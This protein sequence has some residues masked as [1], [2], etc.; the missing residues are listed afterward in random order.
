VRILNTTHR[1][2]KLTRGSPLAH[3]EPVTMVTPPGGEQPQTQDLGSKLEDTVTAARPHLTNGKIQGLE[4]LLT[5]Y[6]DIFAVADE[7]YGRTNKVYHRIE[8]GDARP[9]RQ[10]RG[11]YPWRNKRR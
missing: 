9:I 10:P 3:C 1:D 4:E 11:E 6:E 7:D 2:Q 8:T 5:E